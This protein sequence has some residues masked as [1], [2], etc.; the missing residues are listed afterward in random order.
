MQLKQAHMNKAPPPVP[1]SYQ[2]HKLERASLVEPEIERST[3]IPKSNSNP[4]IAVGTTV[5]AH[6]DPPVADLLSLTSPTPTPKA[7][8]RRRNKKHGIGQIIPKGSAQDV[9]DK[10]GITINLED[11][12]SSDEVDTT[13]TSSSSGDSPIRRGVVP[14]LPPRDDYVTMLQ[15]KIMDLPLTDGPPP[16]PPRDE[17]VT[18]PLLMHNSSSA[19]PLPSRN[20]PSVPVVPPR[21]DIIPLA[22]PREKKRISPNL[23]RKTYTPPVPHKGFDMGPRCNSADVLNSSMPPDESLIDIEE[24]W[25]SEDFGGT[26]ARELLAQTSRTSFTEEIAKKIQSNSF[27]RPSKAVMDTISSDDPFSSSLPPPLIPS[28][29]SST[30]SKTTEDFSSMTAKSDPLDQLLDKNDLSKWL[31]TSS[32][33]QQEKTTTANGNVLT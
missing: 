27:M 16:L 13:S 12:S 23:P 11:H 33:N 1:K 30:A 4:N 2:K 31:S 29:T 18:S 25:V 21:N 3:E 19:P 22:P 10:G 7:P 9:P 6:S 17:L 24:Q 8:P 28:T 26:L 14:P 20:E 5:T 15:P 32:S